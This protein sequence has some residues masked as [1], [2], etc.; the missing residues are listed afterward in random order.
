MKHDGHGVTILL[1]MVVM[2]MI[3]DDD[4]QSMI[5]HVRNFSKFRLSPSGHYWKSARIHESFHQCSLLYRCQGD[6]QL[7]HINLT[8]EKY[9]KNLNTLARFYF[10]TKRKRSK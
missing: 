10:T 4:G 5:E 2:I 3:I 9:A 1:N 6:Q 8:S 7:T